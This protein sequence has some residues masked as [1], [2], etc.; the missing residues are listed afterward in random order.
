MEGMRLTV[1]ENFEYIQAGLNTQ[2][3]EPN[4]FAG[5]DPF[6][7]S[8]DD[9]KGLNG[10][11]NNFRRRTTRNLTKVASESPAYLESAGATPMGDGSGS[12]QLNAGTV[13]RNGY[14]LF[15]VITP[16]YNMYELANFYDTNF[17]N[18]AAIDAKVENVVGLGYRFDITDRTMLSFE[19]S[20]DEGKVDRARN[21][22]ER[23]KIMLRDW[24]EGL[25]DDD[26]FTT[27]MEKVYTEL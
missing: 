10:I 7:K 11:D 4:Q 25:N 8:W 23:A 27:T 15:D 6:A 1:S 14:G 19:M 12:K 3:K 22:I 16:P 9:L 20:D 26:S 18:H 2:Q 5:L 21:R 13:Y 17:A 24:L